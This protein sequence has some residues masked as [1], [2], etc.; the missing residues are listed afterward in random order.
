MSQ[1]LVVD[2]GCKQ[3][4]ATDQFRRGVASTFFKDKRAIPAKACLCVDLQ[5]KYAEVVGSKGYRFKAADILGTIKYPPADYYLA[6]SSLEHMPGLQESDI[7][8]GRMLEAAVKGVWLRVPSFEQDETGEGQLRRHGLRFAW[9][10]WHG[11]PSPW[12]P[13]HF[14][15]FM[16]SNHPALQF[17]I[18]HTKIIKD[19]SHPSVVPVNSPTDTLKYSPELGPKPA[20]QFKPHLI[21]EY[22]IFINK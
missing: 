6:V 5:D 1:F 14:L 22:D 17:R 8:L 16:K 4:G 9:T 3:A 10:D 12:G 20:V 2:L 21:G 15:A 18:R 11:H 7:V 19:S 13:K